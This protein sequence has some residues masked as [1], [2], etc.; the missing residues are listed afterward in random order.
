MRKEINQESDQ[1][2]I[3]KAAYELAFKCTKD[4]KL[5]ASTIIDQY[6]P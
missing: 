1:D 5:I 2:I 6:P 4:M 3:W